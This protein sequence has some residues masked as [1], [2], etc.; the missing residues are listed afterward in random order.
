MMV[1]VKVNDLN[2]TFSQEMH[3]N[4]HTYPFEHIESRGEAGTVLYDKIRAELGVFQSTQLPGLP[5]PQIVPHLFQKQTDKWHTLAEHHLREV[6][7]SVAQASKAM[8]S[9]VCQDI[10]STSPALYLQ[11]YRAVETRF[12]DAFD[13]AREDIRLYC[14]KERT[15]LPQTTDDGFYNKVKAM[16]AL[17]RKRS[18]EALRARVNDWTAEVVEAFYEGHYSS[19]EDNVVNEIHDILRVYYE[20]SFLRITNSLNAVP[21]DHGK[22]SVFVG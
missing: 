12:N 8:L 16:Q 3:D 2:R 1:R 20:V 18:L 19:A 17:R 14:D 10:N 13:R 21:Q 11:L 15:H 22:I 5:N 6:A 4:G 7:D 9:S